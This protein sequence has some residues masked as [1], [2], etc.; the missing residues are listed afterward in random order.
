MNT[1]TTRKA[2]LYDYTCISVP[3]CGA[4]SMLKYRHPDHYTT[5]IY[6]WN[7]D[8]YIF[9]NYAI[10][11]GYRPFG[12]KAN[13]AICTKYNDKA[14]KFLSEMQ[15][16]AISEKTIIETGKGLYTICMEFI[17]EVCAK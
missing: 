9:D 12:I 17:K 6:G 3:Y 14:E 10:V 11:T 4:Y 7:A 1:Q 5:G 2:M 16:K 15:K 8:C 13:S